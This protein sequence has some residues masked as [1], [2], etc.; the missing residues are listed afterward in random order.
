MQALAKLSG[1]KKLQTLNLS[2]NRI[3]L[4]GLELLNDSKRLQEMNAV[5]TDYPHI[6]E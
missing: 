3:D 6:G 1:L 5:K 2:Y 4:Q